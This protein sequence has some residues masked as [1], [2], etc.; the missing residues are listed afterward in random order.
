MLIILESGRGQ[1]P[2]PLTRFYTPVI[3][4]RGLLTEMPS[5]RELFAEPTVRETAAAPDAELMRN[6]L[7]VRRSR[8]AD[9]T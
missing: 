5:I 8:H 7:A 2:I 9:N 6:L 3:R 4:N 1:V